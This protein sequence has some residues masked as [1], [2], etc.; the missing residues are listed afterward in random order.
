MTDVKLP[1]PLLPPSPDPTRCSAQRTGPAW[2]ISLIIPAAVTLFTAGVALA[3]AASPTADIVA[4]SANRTLPAVTEPSGKFTLPEPVTTLAL[5]QARLFPESLVPVGIVAPTAAENEALALALRAFSAA[6]RDLAV[7]DAFVK[8]NPGSPWLPSLMTNL[9]LLKYEAGYFTDALARWNGAWVLG[10]KAASGEKTAPIVIRALAEAVR[11]NCRVGRAAEAK[12]LLAQLGD[13]PV[14]GVNGS[15]LEHARQA[16]VQMETAPADSFKCGP[17]ALMSILSHQKAHTP[18]TYSTIT[19]YETTAQGTSLAQVAALAQSLGMKMQPAKRIKADA[20][21]PLPAVVNWTLHHYGALLEAKD[22]RYLLTDPTFGTSQWIAADALAKNASGYFLLPA[23]TL[24]PGWV[25]VAEA[26]AGTVW[27]RGNC[28]DGDGNKTGKKDPKKPDCPKKKR[29]MAVWSIHHSLASLNLEDSPLAYEP[30]VGPVIE[31]NVNY[32]QLEKNQPTTLN[33]SNVGPLWNFSW[34]SYLTFDSSN[35]FLRSGGGGS[36]LFTRFNGGTGAYDPEQAGGSTLFRINASRYEIREDDGSK[37]VFSTVD[38]SGRLFLTQEVDPQGNAITYTYDANF[39]LVA[40]TDAVGQVTVVEHG[41]NTPGDPLF[42]RVTKVTDPF[43]RFTTLTYDANQRLT[44]TTD[45]IGIVSQFSYNAQSLITR[46]TTPYGNTDFAFGTSSGTAAGN[47]SF[48]EVREPNGARQRVESVQTSVIPA[49]LTAGQIPIGMPAHNDFLQWRNSFYW[50]AKGMAQ[51]PGDYSKAEI[52]HFLHLNVSNIKGSIPESIKSPLEGRVW[53]YYQGQNNSIFT[54]EGMRAN[55]THIGRVLDDGTT[56]LDRFT[57]NSMGKITQNIDP[58]GRTTNYTY[59]ANDIDLLKIEQVN[60]EGGLDLLATYTWN[61]QHL[62]VTIKDAGGA[63]TTFAYNP[64]GQV[65]NVVNAVGQSTV[66]AYD[67]LGGLLSADG[68]LPNFTDRFTFTYDAAGRVRTV[69]NAEGDIVTFEHDAL[70][71]VTKVTY[72]D[73]DFEETI[74][75]RLDTTE[76]RDQSGRSTKLAFNEI[77]QPTKL[78]DYLGRVTLLEWCVCGSLKRL[79]DPLNRVTS[80]EQDLQ[81]RPISKTYPDGSKETYQYEKTTSRLSATQDAK[82]QVKGFSYQIDDA[83]DRILYVHAAQETPAVT[84]GYDKAYRRLTTMTDGTGLT[85]YSYHPVASAGSAG[86]NQLAAVTTGWTVATVTFTYDALGRINARAINGVPQSVSHD[87]AGRISAITNALGT[88]G[89]T[90]ENSS[91]RVTG[92][93]LPNGQS[94]A[95]TYFGNGSQRKLKQTKNLLPGGSILSQFDY[96]YDAIGRLTSWSQQSSGGAAVNYSLGYDA[97]D[98][99]VSANAAGKLQ[100]YSYDPAGNILTR[101]S[102]NGNTNLTY[103]ILNELQS[104]SPPL[105]NNPA[106]TYLW[107]AENRL[108]GINFTGTSQ[109]TRLTYDGMGRCVE[110]G[111][112]N[113]S[114]PV[115]VKRF[116]WCGMERAEERDAAGNVT[117]RF[118]AQGEQVGGVDYFYTFDHLGSVREMTDQNGAMRARYD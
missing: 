37:Q 40:V 20:A 16:I 21:L 67:A 4:P 92:I 98:Q 97:L 30:P 91:N 112:Y 50:D 69:T 49:T 102:N 10:S 87:A 18:S 38:P 74:Y 96:G 95:A 63:V 3:N 22:G 44:S 57:Y 23:G 28:P 101:G 51:A 59:A 75:T 108:T 117:R 65:T 58:L 33:F 1:P 43:G 115:S 116:V 85:S 64:R 46:L 35:A 7:L 52:T 88:F 48:V 12:A 94:V 114:T 107:D 42:Y 77:Q 70:D 47:I 19:R 54:N 76:V 9:G 80:W 110:I 27:G 68:P 86:A 32:S 72:P 17:F 89:Y 5:T 15:L 41:S 62:P 14:S 82:G 105:A 25:A 6:G 56:Q 109:N 13:R 73:G 61:A 45:T 93:S 66:F 36:E 11:M 2:F 24:P 100:T 53:F 103:N 71:R 31:F 29:G 8:S 118:F 81:S 84:F 111:E 90:F 99:L 113:G 39:R 26:E 83:L 60:V 79:I 78:T 106:K 104:V 34:L 55:P